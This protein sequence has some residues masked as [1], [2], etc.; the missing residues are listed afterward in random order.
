MFV[1]TGSRGFIGQELVDYLESQGHKV[2]AMDWQDRGRTWSVEEPIEW[3][4]H[5]GA[6]SST[7]ADSWEELVT[8]NIKDTQG[9]IRFAEQH[10]CGITY[11]SSASIYG[12]WTNSP[13]WGPVQ[14]QHLYGVS[15]LAVDNWC[16]EQQFTVPVQGVRFFNVYGRKEQH[17]RQPS[18][19]RR[20]LDQAATKRQL[21][22]WHHNGRYGSRDFISIDDTIHA[23][24]CLRQA[25]VSGV[26]NIGTGRTDT[27]Y[28]IAKTCQRLAGVTNCQMVVTSMPEHMLATYQWESCANLDKLRLVLPDW[29]PEN[30]HDWLERNWQMLYNKTIEDMNHEIKNQ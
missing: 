19:V 30:I 11:A 12:P 21:T 2:Y 24:E 18:P 28:D 15:K 6:I 27:F 7:D 23:M 16:A 9:W 29:N 14:P 3:I 22:V 10:R 8:K 26:Y 13:E 5:M 4:Y 20:Y 17:K 1:V 25:R